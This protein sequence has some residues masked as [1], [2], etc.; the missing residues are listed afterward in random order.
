[1]LSR[2][3]IFSGLKEILISM[4]PSKEEAMNKVNEST[5]LVEDLGLMSVSLLYMVI[6]I[7]ER[8]NI[9]LGNVGVNDFQTVGDVITYIQKVSE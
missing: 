5:K 3:E 7:E 9:D 8:F 4:D 6:S 2:D 1:M